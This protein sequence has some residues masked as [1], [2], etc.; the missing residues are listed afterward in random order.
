MRLRT[1]CTFADTDLSMIAP[2][3]ERAY[4]AMNFND[5][6][7]LAALAAAVSHMAVLFGQQKFQSRQAAALAANA[8]I[9]KLICVLGQRPCKSQSLVVHVQI[10]PG[11]IWWWRVLCADA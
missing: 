9:E 10:E 2:N 8:Q 7:Y 1:A 5:M 11:R 3:Y 4:R 6:P